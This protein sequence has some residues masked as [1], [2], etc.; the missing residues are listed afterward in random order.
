MHALEFLLH[1]IKIESDYPTFY[2]WLKQKN[3]PF[4][5][6]ADVIIYSINVNTNILGQFDLKRTF[7]RQQSYIFIVYR[8]NNLERS[9][10]TTRVNL[11]TT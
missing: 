1:D 3:F 11:V 7:D 8:L 10:K 6:Y 2:K 4:P 5:H 9:I